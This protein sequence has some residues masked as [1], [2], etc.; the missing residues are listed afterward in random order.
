[1]RLPPEEVSVHFGSYRDDGRGQFLRSKVRG[2][3]AHSSSVYGGGAGRGAVD[4]KAG[5]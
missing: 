4:G 5:T 2:Q 1:M 3:E